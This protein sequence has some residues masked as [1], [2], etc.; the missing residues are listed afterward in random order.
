MAWLRNI[1]LL[2]V[3]GNAAFFGYD[4]YNGGHVYKEVADNLKNI[5]LET[6]ATSINSVFAQLKNV[7][8]PADILQILRASSIF[9]VHADEGS[10]LALTSKTF[11]TVIDG[12]KPALVEFYAPWCGHC[13]NLAP[14]YEQ[15]ADA[16]A[17]AKDEVIIAKVDADEHKDLGSKFGVTGF[18][19]LKWFPKGV[20]EPEKVEDFG[21]GRDLDSLAGFIRDKTGIRAKIK[22]VPSAVTVLTTAN[23]DKIVLDSDKDVLVEFYAPWCGHC[24]SLAPV[25]EKVATAFATESK[26]IVAKIDAE[27]ERTIGEKYGITGFPTIKFFSKDNKE[28]EA[29]EAGRSEEDFIKYLNEKCG[30]HRIPGGDLDAEAGK[31]PELDELTQQFMATKDVSKREK[32][33]SAAESVAAADSD[34]FAKYYAIVMKKTT[35]DDGFVDKESARLEKLSKGDVTRLKK[36]EITIRRNILTVFKPVEMKDEL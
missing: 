24:K 3:L 13:K 2:T 4:T 8:K 14:I 28:G 15:L 35:S 12:S 21:G 10:V 33:I 5:T 18:P 1:V 27:G 31:I 26:C 32:L 25:Y 29:Y 6:I 20:T 34:K 22:V 9:S 19:T 16:Y 7:Q 17:F 36:D 23:F 30:T 11:D